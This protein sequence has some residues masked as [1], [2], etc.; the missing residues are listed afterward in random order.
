MTKDSVRKWLEIAIRAFL[1]SLL[2]AVLG[3]GFLAALFPAPTD[4]L[5]PL[6]E[7]FFFPWG[8]VSLLASGVLLVL[9][10]AIPKEVTSGRKPHRPARNPFPLAL[11]HLRK[12]LVLVRKVT[13][14]PK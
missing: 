7:V 12:L 13:P 11:E 8:W 6:V 9:Y 3:P 1:I 5:L 10:F 2:F 4:E 14:A